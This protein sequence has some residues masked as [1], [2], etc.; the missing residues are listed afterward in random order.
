MHVKQKLIQEFMKMNDQPKSFKAIREDSGYAMSDMG[1]FSKEVDVSY[2][3]ADRMLILGDMSY[4]LDKY[5]LKPAVANFSVRLY[6]RQTDVY[7]TKLFNAQRN[8]YGFVPLLIFIAWFG[9]L[10]L[11]GEK[12][13]YVFPIVLV[14][15]VASTMAPYFLLSKQLKSIGVPLGK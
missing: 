8:S 1:I 15:V 9:A 6:E 10:Y 12:A 7:A 13:A 2:R 4:S 14:G 11:M 5:Y 3:P